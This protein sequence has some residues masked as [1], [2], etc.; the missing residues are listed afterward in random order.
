MKNILLSSSAIVLGL[1]LASCTTPIPQQLTAQNVPSNFS[2]PITTDAP[3]WPKA[4]WW[5]GFGSDELDGL[6]DEAQRDNLDLALAAAQ[7][8]EAKANAEIAGSILWPQ[9]DVSGTAD[10]TRTPPSQNIAIPG[11]GTPRSTNNSFSLTGQA[12]W[13]LDIWGKAQDDLRAA[14]EQVKASRFAKEAVALTVISGTGSTYFNVLALRERVT[15][16]QANIDAAN[17]VLAITQAKVTNGVSSRLDLAQQEAQV[18]GQKAQIPPLEE[19]ER[20]ARYALAILLG[21]LPEGFNVQA[22]NLDKIEAPAVRPGLPSELLR[23]RPDVAEAEANLAAAHANV[24][25]ARAAFFPQ[26][27]LTGSAGWASGALKSLIGPGN[28]AWSI[29]G[30]LLQTI[31]DGGNLQ[32]QY[33]VSKA[34]QLQLVATYRKTV[35]TAFQDVETSLGQVASLTQQEKFLTDEVNAASEAFRISEIQYREG[36][37]DLLTVLTAQQTLFSAQDQLV[38]IKLARI[39][40]DVGLYRALGGGWS[41]ADE[42]TTQTLPAA[43]APVTPSAEPGPESVPAAPVPT[44]PGPSQIPD[45]PI[46]PQPSHV[47]H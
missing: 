45:E 33:R 38:Q 16:A 31:F 34:Q 47:H 29:G 18:A 4:D 5:K 25:A 17:R 2:A 9:L 37:T 41:E 8:M 6:I 44:T 7:V 27:G 43:T 39:Q 11:F 15:I 19:G 3:V 36:V 28:F 24:D 35:L 26:I 14:D 1:A 30:S 10:R 40:A 32:G 12:S 42:L 23:R 20:E 13:A 21:K 46:P 22:Q